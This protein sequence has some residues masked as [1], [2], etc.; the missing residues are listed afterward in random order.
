LIVQSSR[1]SK[2]WRQK[3]TRSDEPQPLGALLGRSC[4]SSLSR[5][6]DRH[7]DRAHQRSNA[8]SARQSPPRARATSS[9]KFPHHAYRHR[10]FCVPDKQEYRATDP[11]QVGDG[12]VLLPAVVVVDRHLGV[13]IDRARS[14][15]KYS[16][17]PGRR[18]Y[19]GKQT[20]IQRWWCLPGSSASAWAT[21]GGC[22]P[23]QRQE[24]TA[25]PLRGKRVR[26]LRYTA[27]EY[28]CSLP[29]RIAKIWVT[30]D[31]GRAEWAAILTKSCP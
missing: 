25:A 7:R 21:R 3:V 27:G 22:R 24:I 13:S 18:P 11:V 30:S 6:R 9:T 20:C 2:S 19:S 23:A 31:Q 15:R 1:V 12:P 4:R 28:A 17:A 8:T 10:W 5:P 14:C 26:Q 29:L 16:S